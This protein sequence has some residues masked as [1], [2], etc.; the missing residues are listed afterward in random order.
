MLPV[1]ENSKIGQQGLE[2]GPEIALWHSSLEFTVNRELALGIGHHEVSGPSH[3]ILIGILRHQYTPVAAVGLGVLQ[4]HAD[5]GAP[6]LLADFLVV[7]AH[8]MASPAILGAE[9]Q[10]HQRH[11]ARASARQPKPRNPHPGQ[12]AIDRD[13]PPGHSTNHF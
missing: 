10:D 2:S 13:R 3:P 7:M 6:E 12:A 9:L 4:H 5:K 11:G 1:E 8:A